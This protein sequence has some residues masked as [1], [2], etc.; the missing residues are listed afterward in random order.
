[1]ARTHSIM[2]EL[3]SPAPDFSLP[4]PAANRVVSLADFSGQALVVAFICNHCPYVKHM[5]SRFSDMAQRYM[6]QGIAFVAINSNDVEHY[7]DDSPE[8]MAGFAREH[9]FGFPYLFDAPQAV[10]KA[11]RP[12]S[13]YLMRHTG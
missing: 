11:Y 8:R 2:L 1:M 12:I 13:F 5:I 4:E 7:P 9:G 10:A 3:G 6:T